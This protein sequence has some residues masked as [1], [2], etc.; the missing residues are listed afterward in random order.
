MGKN[1]VGCQR[2][3]KEHGKVK[4]GEAAWGRMERDVKGWERCGMMGKDEG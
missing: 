2:M 3:V 4:K 1:W